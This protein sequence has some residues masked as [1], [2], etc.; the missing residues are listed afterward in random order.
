MKSDILSQAQKDA[1][2]SPI[3]QESPYGRMIRYEDIFD[4]IQS[5]R[6]VRFDE[7][8]ADD[9]EDEQQEPEEIDWVAIANLCIDALSKHSK[10]L[11]LGFWLTEAWIH[12]YGLRGMTE[13]LSITAQLLEHFIVPLA[14]N[15]TQDAMA[16]LD[17]QLG[18]I[19]WANNKFSRVFYTIYI[20]EKNNLN[21]RMITL[22][23][24]H[25]HYSFKQGNYVLRENEPGAD[26][27][28][29]QKLELAI[30]TSSSVFRSCLLEALSQVY[31]VITKMDALLSEYFSVDR[32]SLHALG[33]EIKRFQSVITKLYKK[34][35]VNP[36]VEPKPVEEKPEQELEDAQQSLELPL[37]DESMNTLVV[38]DPKQSSPFTSQDLSQFLE[39]IDSHIHSR[40]D[41]YEIAQVLGKKLCELDPQSPIPLMLLRSSEWG[42]LDL[43]A[44]LS[45]MRDCNISMEQFYAL[46][47]A[48]NQPEA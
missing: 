35:R 29:E 25:K 44:I 12:L 28:F 15:A 24:F 31:A 22:F 11:I 14:S 38:V 42:R 18:C 32:A 2:L 19:N 9:Q 10:D 39:L 45:R 36:I 17:L 43:G 21:E 40:D 34:F 33:S 6:S 16:F 30:S 46:L 47:A 37:V 23:D 13:G 20:N 48:E 8:V 7:G 3:S 26:A 41:L 4:E 5:K 27:D 1:I